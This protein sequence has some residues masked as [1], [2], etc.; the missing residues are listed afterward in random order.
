MKQRS[1]VLAIQDTTG[2]TYKH[3]VCEDLGDV[4]CANTQKK[5]PRLERYMRTQHLF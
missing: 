2:L 3:S 4:S 1:L 5:Y